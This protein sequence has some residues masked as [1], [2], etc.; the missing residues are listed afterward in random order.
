MDTSLLLERAQLLLEQ[1]RYKDAETYIRQALEQ[2]PDND[3]ILSMLGRCYIN[4]RRYDE[5][6]EVMQQAI[7]IDPNNSFCFY[8]LGF[9]YYQKN[10]AFAAKTNLQKAIQLNPYSPEYFGLLAHVL[11]EER[12]FEE[13]LEKANEGLT[14][15]ADNITCLNA[16]SV[17]LNK[18]KRTEDAFET[19]STA[20]AQD[21]DNEVTHNVVGWN[22]LE[23]GQHKE[24]ASHFMEALRINPDYGN[25]KVGLKEA[26][27]SRIFLYKW[28]LQ[29]SFWMH[30]KGRSMQ[31]ALP[32]VFYILF[33][34][35]V[36][37]S[38]AGGSETGL[39]W[40]LIGI[41]LFV[42]VIS[43]TIGSIANLVLLVHPLGKHALT[44]KEKWSAIASVSALAAGIVTMIISGLTNI[45][46]G[47]PY[48]GNLFLAGM[49]CLSLALPLGLIHYPIRLQK[50]NKKQLFPLVLIGFG[51]LALLVFAVVPSASGAMFGIYGLA[52]L[53]Y[54]W[55]GIFR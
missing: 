48:E 9:A 2:D 11:V 21:P 10:I 55:S 16:R 39:T 18:L 32:I 41:Y 36:G 45:G 38:K 53:I 47:S 46:A 29:Y 20:L 34:V 1:N 3:Y 12:E 15:D 6:I 7:A 17:A 50:G 28:L 27:K 40:L 8:L 26:L 4:S 49:V 42:V 14:L 23:R 51:L 33:R 19:M 52:F 44:V 35:L 30:N 24:A 13:A 54:N 37:L 22:L 5:G 31:V 43:W 25:A